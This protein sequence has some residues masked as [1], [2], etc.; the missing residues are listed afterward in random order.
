VKQLVAILLITGVLMQSMS[1]YMVQLDY[2][3]NKDYIAKNLCENRNKPQM[4]CCGKCHLNKQLN[5]TENDN[6]KGKTVQRFSSFEFY[7]SNYSD[8]F[9]PKPVFITSVEISTGFV[10]DQYSYRPLTGVFHP[11]QV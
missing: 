8:N 7:A 11:P 3:I 1:K 6:S 2:L 4:K 5:K 9:Y 10:T